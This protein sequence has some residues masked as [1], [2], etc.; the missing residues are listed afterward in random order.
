VPARRAILL[1]DIINSQQIMTG[2]SRLC[3]ESLMLQS[4]L[5]YRTFRRQS[6]ADLSFETGL[7]K[8]FP[9]KNYRKEKS[10]L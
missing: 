4:A 7:E 5:I 3:S 2:F 1:G 10:L 9:Q 6:A 8:Q